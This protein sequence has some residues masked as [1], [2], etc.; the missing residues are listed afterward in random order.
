MLLPRC[1]NPK[2][3]LGRRFLTFRARRVPRRPS[4]RSR[5]RLVDRDVAVLIGTR[6]SRDARKVSRKCFDFRGSRAELPT[7]R[8]PAVVSCRADPAG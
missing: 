6:R 4:P 2:V 3:S 1:T 7:G 8:D 5:L